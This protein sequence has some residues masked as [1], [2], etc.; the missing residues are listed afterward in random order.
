M[1]EICFSNSQSVLFC[2]IQFAICSR[3]SCI[4]WWI[5]IYGVLQTSSGFMLEKLF[6]FIWKWS[7]VVYL[8]VWE[9]VFFFCLETAKTWSVCHMMLRQ[10]YFKYQL[11]WPTWVVRQSRNTINSKWLCTVYYVLTN[12]CFCTGFPRWTTSYTSNVNCK[13]FI[14]KYY[15]KLVLMFGN[16]TFILY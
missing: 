15:L 9:L 14:Q 2:I 6:I 10:K 12:M 3:N 8:N 11:I 4:I 16:S 1:L 13:L 7:F 5:I